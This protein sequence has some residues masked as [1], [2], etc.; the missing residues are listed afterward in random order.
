MNPQIW[1]AIG[2]MSAFVSVGCGAFGVHGLEKVLDPRMLEVWRT[3]A[4]YQMYH[5]FAMIAWGLWAGLHT[6]TNV[7]PHY[8]GW[9]FLTGTVLFSGSLY[10]LALTGIRVL[11]AITPIGGL[12]FLLGWILFAFVALKT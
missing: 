4:Q 3:G 8:P 12:A 9:A 10:A 1:V 6:R 7:F 5:A 2:A 11:G